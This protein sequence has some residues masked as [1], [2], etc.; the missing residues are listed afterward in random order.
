M[1]LLLFELDY[2]FLSGWL[3]WFQNTTKCYETS[4]TSYLGAVVSVTVLASAIKLPGSNWFLK[5]RHDS[6]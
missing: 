4:L 1:N 6:F 2:C 5:R 3:W